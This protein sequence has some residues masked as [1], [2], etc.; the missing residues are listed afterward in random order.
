[1]RPG[2]ACP[3][4]GPVGLGAPPSPGRCSAQTA[5]LS[6]A[7]HCACRS[8]PVTLSAA[9]RSC[10][11]LRAHERV[12][13]ARP[14]QGLGAPGPQA[15]MLTRR[16]VA[17]PRSPVTPLHACP[18]LR[19]RWCPQHSPLRA[20]DCCLPAPENR[21]RSPRYDLEGEPAVH[22]S[23]PG[24]APSHGLRPRYTRLRTPPC[25]D[26][27]GCATD[28]LARRSSGGIGAVRLAPTG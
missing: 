16:Q 6:V 23:T 5:R 3:P 4:V 12:E 17:L 18:A 13:A 22:D 19:P 28:R 27:R 25:G 9:V 14:R 21:R 24:G 1:V 26:A 11:P 10:S 20:Q 2:V 8:R 7:G 15:G